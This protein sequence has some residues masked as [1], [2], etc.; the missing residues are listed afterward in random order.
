MSLSA[1]DFE[2]LLESARHSAV[3]LEMRDVYSSGEEADDFQRW[4]RTG[5]AEM[6][7]DSPHWSA[8]TNLVRRTVARGVLVRRARIISEP[9][10]EYIRYEHITTAVNLMAGED[11]RWLPRRRASDIALPGND[12]WLID[13]EVVLWNFFTG[14]GELAGHEITN[15]PTVAALCKSAFESV[16]ER[17]IPHAKY[18]A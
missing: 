18:S 9:V 16:W 3:H 4:Q 15:E 8:W 6:N 12:F 13:G 5:T 17:G 10:T 14:D 7:P 1:E 2:A 11:V